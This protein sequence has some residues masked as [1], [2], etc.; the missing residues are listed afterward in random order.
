MRAYGLD[1][2]KRG[3]MDRLERSGGGRHEAIPMSTPLSLRDGK[4]RREWSVNL[5]QRFIS[6]ARTSALDP[7]RGWPVTYAFGPIH[8]DS[9]ARLISS[10][11]GPVHLTRKGFDLL[12]L[13]LENRPNAVS[14]EQIYARVWPDTFVAESSLQFLVHEIRHALHAGGTRPSWIRT[15]HGIGYSF[16]GDVLVSNPTSATPGSERPAAWLLGSSI[17][18]ALRSGENI[19]GRGSADVVDIDAPTIS[20]RHARIIVGE[21]ITLEDLGSKN[22]TWLGDE[23][24]TTLHV[25]AD[26]DVLK[27]GSATFTFR[28]A[29]HPRPTESVDDRSDGSHLSPQ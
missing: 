23:R 20:R 7:T 1:W 10:T 2:L 3:S 12:L 5:E 15:V 28:L 22:G 18:V 25:L 8:V 19:V 14:K 26:G 27:L 13:L 29:R 17:R 9:Q 24:L 6:I 21:S 4:E 16:C 11:A